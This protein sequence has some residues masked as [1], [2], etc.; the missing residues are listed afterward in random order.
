MNLALNKLIL[1]AM[2]AIVFFL[3]INMFEAETLIYI[4]NSTF[5]GCQHARKSPQRI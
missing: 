3:V 5:A 4:M 1:S 2:A